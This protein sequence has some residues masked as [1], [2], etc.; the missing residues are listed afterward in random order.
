MEKWKIATIA[1]LLFALFGFG[2]LQSGGTNPSPTPPPAPSPYLG[3][4][5]PAWNFKTWNGKPVSQP[6]LRGKPAFIEIFRI[7]CPHCQDAAPFLVALHARY[8]PR[9]LKV[10]SIQSPGDFKNAEN[11]ENSWPTVQTWL[12]E[13][14]ID[15][16]VAFDAGSK[17]FQG[18]VK[19]QVLGGKNDNLLYPTMIFTD[20][21]G[22][23]DFSQ[24]GYDITKALTLAIEMEK[25]FPTSPDTEKSADDLANWLSKNLPELGITGDMKKALRD[26]IAQRLKGKQ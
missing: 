14:K 25:R 9:G 18:T 6:E 12:K 26:D 15:Y 5:L 8:A 16:P 23:I 24:T 20:K 21:A 1:A 19:K 11:P 22:K 3:K 4:T 2:I 7:E 17:Y 10:V 13:R